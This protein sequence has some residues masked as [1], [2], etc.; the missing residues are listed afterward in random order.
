ML[1]LF[2]ALKE[3]AGSSRKQKFFKLLGKSGTFPEEI[4]ACF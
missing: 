4:Y 3:Y 1:G 2:N